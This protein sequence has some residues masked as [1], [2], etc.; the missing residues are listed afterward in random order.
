MAQSPPSSS[1]QHTLLAQS[2]VGHV[3]AC[4]DCGVVHLSLYCV[5]V[6]LELSAFVALTEMLSQAHKRLNCTQTPAAPTLLE[7]THAVH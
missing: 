7:P 1:C 3:S 5:T 6:R 4:S 2:P